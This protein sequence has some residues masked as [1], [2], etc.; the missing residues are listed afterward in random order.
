MLIGL[1]SQSDVKRAAVMHALR[2]FGVDAQLIAVKAR[3]DVS[4]QPFHNETIIGARNRATHAALLVPGAS[5]T[6]AIESG[7]FA[8]NGGYFDIAIVVARLP[9]AEFLQQESAAV[10]VPADAVEEVKRRGADCWTI[11]KILQERGRVLDH[12]DPHLCL[13][14]R[15]RAEFLKDALVSLFQT[16]RARELL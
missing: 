3:S 14:G 1:G 4:E 10:A 9:T 12:T 13:V 5:F 7:L 2:Q 8:R 16:M 11:G 6:L 15:S